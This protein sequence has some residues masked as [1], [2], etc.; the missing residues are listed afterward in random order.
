[1]EIGAFAFMMTLYLVTLRSPVLAP[2]D[3]WHHLNHIVVGGGVVVTWAIAFGT[4]GL[5]YIAPLITIPSAL[6]LLASIL[7]RIGHR[8]ADLTLL[9][10]ESLRSYFLG[11]IRKQ[12]Q[13]LPDPLH[14]IALI[15]G[16]KA[17]HEYTEDAEMFFRNP[18][19]ARPIHQADRAAHWAAY[20]YLLTRDPY[21]YTYYA[22][23]LDPDD[24]GVTAIQ[25]WFCYYYN[26]WAYAHQGDWEMAVVLLK[27]GKPYGAA[28]SQ[29]EA[30]EYRPWERI[31]R[32]GDRPVL[33]IAAGSHSVHFTPGAHVAERAIAGLRLTSLDAA[34]FGRQVLEFVDFTVPSKTMGAVIENARVVLLPDPDAATSLW[35]HHDHGNPRCPGACERDFTWLNFPGHWGSVTFSIIGGSSGPRGPA[36]QGVE[37]DNPRMWAETVCRRSL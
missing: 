23:V 24:D 33:Y 20:A 32:Q 1:V 16:L 5:W 34:Q 2:V 27:D 29:H 36:Y 22:R 10:V 15:H 19:N 4:R 26:D 14:H 35:G 37:W 3:N 9:V 30:G 31:E 25:Y 21:P 7:L 11:V 18:R 13:R 8:L 28:G 12:K 6:S 17:A